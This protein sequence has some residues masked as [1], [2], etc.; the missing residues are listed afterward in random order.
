MLTKLAL[1]NP[2]ALLGI[3][4]GLLATHGLVGVQA[5]KLGGQAVEVAWLQEKVEAEKQRAED[6]LAAQGVSNAYQLRL[7]DLEDSA[8]NRPARSVRMC[9]ENPLPVPGSP[10]GSDGATENGVSGTAGPDIGPRLTGLALDADRCS[11]QLSALQ[12]WVR[13][14]AKTSR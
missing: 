11:E 13:M 3:A 6:Q 9:L 1:A 7:R 12:E 8:R 4:A 5:Y 2:W 14:V 10:G